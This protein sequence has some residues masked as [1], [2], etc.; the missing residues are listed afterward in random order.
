MTLPQ[1]RTYEDGSYIRIS[2]IDSYMYWRHNGRYFTAKKD[3]YKTN[4]VCSYCGGSGIYRGDR[5]WT[6]CICSILESE[7]LL[8]EY[9]IFGN[10]P[11][12]KSLDNFSIW[13]DSASQDAL[14]KATDTVREWLG[15]L[16]KWLVMA[17]GV[18][19]GKSHIMQAIH[20]H[21]KPWSLYLSVADLETHVFNHTNSHDLGD[22]MEIVSKH[23]ILLL[24]DVGADY[25]AKYPV[26]KLRGVLSGRY[27]M[28]WEYPT[29]LTTNLTIEQLIVYDTRITDRILDKHMSKVISLSAV[30]SW[31]RYGE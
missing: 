25:G 28:A 26:A 30:K 5:G 31:R 8:Q 1:I 9:Q 27:D 3:G 22:V 10:S 21:F 24:D 2:K 6:R 14:I 17:G 7:K 15:S 29:V 18:G 13:G 19:V 20:N 23:P 12:R 4:G 16:D 11:S